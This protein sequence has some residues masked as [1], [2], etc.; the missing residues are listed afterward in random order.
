[1]SC[2]IHSFCET[3]NKSGKWN[4]VGEVFTTL[5]YGNDNKWYGKP[6]EEPIHWQDYS[7][8]GFLANVRNYDGSEVLSEPKDLPK[9]VSDEVKDSA[10]EWRGNA[11]SHSYFTLEELL[12]F[13]YD[14][15]LVIQ[16]DGCE[17]Y[18]KTLTYRENLGSNWFDTLDVMKT[19]GAPAD[20]RIVFWFDN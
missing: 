6:T 7:L 19:L 10:E 2:D 17:N 13:D 12:A 15:T 9:D 14:K 4:T 8:F 3:K 16:R 1:M 11:H 5:S 18:G 20:V